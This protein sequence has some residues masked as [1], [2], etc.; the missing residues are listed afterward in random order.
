MNKLNPWAVGGALAITAAIVYLVCAAVVFLWPG[1]TLEFFNA[2]FHG[3]DLSALKAT[4]PMTAAVFFYGLSGA[5]V[6]TF[7]VGA[8]FAVSYNLVR[9]CPGCR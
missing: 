2:W 8:V 5:V 6:S 9:R 3:L 1:G 4:K 7:A